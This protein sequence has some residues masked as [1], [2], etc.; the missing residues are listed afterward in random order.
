[1]LDALMAAI[2]ELK[3]RGHQV[4]PVVVHPHSTNTNPFS[5]RDH[6]FWSSGA[7][8][9]ESSRFYEKIDGRKDISHNLHRGRNFLIIP[10]LPSYF[11][12]TIGGE[13]ET[14]MSQNG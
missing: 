8:I 2:P 4:P 14:I 6:Y 3:H 7:P 13:T 5:T 11:M 12:Y 1:M 9:S 10:K